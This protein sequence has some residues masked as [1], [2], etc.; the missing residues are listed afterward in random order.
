MTA[1]IPLAVADDQISAI[2]DAFAKS[3]WNAEFSRVSG[4]AGS[5]F[6]SVTCERNGIRF[7]FDVYGPDRTCG[8]LCPRCNTQV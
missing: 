6:W 5:E 3:D 2:R 1:P 7:G 8:G 4:A